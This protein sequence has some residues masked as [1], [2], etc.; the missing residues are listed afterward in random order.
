MGQSILARL[1]RVETR[2]VEL[3]GPSQLIFI[4]L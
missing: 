1:S 4:S 3:D 2:V